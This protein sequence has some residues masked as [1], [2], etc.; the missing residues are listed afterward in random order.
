MEIKSFINQNIRNSLK[1]NSLLPR[2]YGVPKIHK[3]NYP[4][5]IIVFTINS[6]LYYFSLYLHKIIYISILN[7]PF[8]VKDSFHLFDVISGLDLDDH[9]TLCS[10]DVVSLFTNVPIELALEGINNRWKYKKLNT[11]INQQEF[12]LALR[13][14][15]SSTYFTFDHRMYKQTYGTPMGLPLSPIKAD[16]TMQYL[17][18]KA[19]NALSFSLP[20]YYRYVDDIILAIP[21]N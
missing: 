10:F 16:I 17:E 21:A 1:Q 13:F 15:M 9:H 3:P 19:L 6:P 11:K 5:R 2:V 4:F 18:L 7:S 14:V 20:F 8:F 12:I